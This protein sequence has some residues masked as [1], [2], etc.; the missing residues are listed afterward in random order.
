MRRIK[1]ATVPDA[2]RTRAAAAEAIREIGKAQRELARIEA[3][4]NERLDAIRKTCEARAA[5]HRETIG[6]KSEGVRVWCEA[7][8]DELTEGG[9]VKTAEMGSG[10]VKW[11]LRPPSVRVRGL[12]DVIA[13]LKR[14]GLQRFLRVKTELDKEAI[15]AH[16][17]QVS[18]VAGIAIA[19]AEDF[20]I[21]PNE[22]RLEQVVGGKAA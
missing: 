9:K 13:A 10:T 12:E 14:L 20:V 2:P 19:Q 7:H 18:R 5:P 21:E 17:E 8:R 4:M 1:T 22:T 3:E 15:L 11:R 16:P 6:R